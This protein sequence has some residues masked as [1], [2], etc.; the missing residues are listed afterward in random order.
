MTL[1][2]I[3]YQFVNWRDGMKITQK[4]LVQHDQAIREAIRDVAAIRLTPY[5]YGLLPADD[6]KSAGLQLSVL[7]DTL[8]L[9]SCRGIT[10]GGLRIE[11]QCNDDPDA[12]SISLLDYRSRLGTTG[13]FYVVLRASLGQLIEDGPYD[14]EE[15]PMR[16]PFMTLKPAL[17]LV[18]VHEQLSD[19]YSFPI[20]RVRLEGQMIMPDY[21]YVPPSTGVFG[22]TLSWY[23]ETCGKSLN[24]IH[25]TAAAIVRKIN[26]MQQPSPVAKDILTTAGKLVDQG[27]NC[28]EAYRLLAGGQPPAFFIEQLCRYARTFK[29]VVSCFSEQSAAR[30][31]QYLQNNIAGSSQVNVQIREITRSFVESLTDAVLTTPYVHNDCTVLLDHLKTFLDF[32][33]FM[34]QNL[35]AL[36]YVETGRWD[37]A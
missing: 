32:L 10:P 34:L 31:Y 36:P 12:V 26:G 35:L 23:Y 24:S 21:E 20:F 8:Q 37:I 5:N 28:L 2:T 11:W 4:H 16:K 9:V 25:H 17:D 7:N 13:T 27:I 3:G 19:A 30:F 6:G 22:E 33:E 15:L 29:T 1:P 14:P 18:S